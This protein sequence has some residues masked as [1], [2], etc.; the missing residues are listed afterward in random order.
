MVRINVSKK[1]KSLKQ[2]LDELVIEMINGQIRYLDAKQEFEKCFLSRIIEREN[3]NLSRAAQTLNIH[4]NT[5]RKKMR[6]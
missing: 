2:K 6:T 4:R 1:K 5:L 3:G